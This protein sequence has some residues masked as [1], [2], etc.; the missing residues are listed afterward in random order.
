V[1]TGDLRRIADDFGCWPALVALIAMA[2][3][4][5]EPAGDGQ[6]GSP[7]AV[8]GFTSGAGTNAGGTG[9]GVCSGHTS[10]CYQMCQ[11]GLCECFCPTTGGT[12][13]GTGGA[14]N[15]GGSGG[16][17]GLCGSNCTLESTSSPFC[18]T[19]EVSVVCHGPFPADLGSIM[20]SHACTDAGTGA[21]R[22]CCPA[23][24]VSEC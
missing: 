22:Y 18:A 12:G 16:G 14:A 15:L 5:T 19:A 2:C 7:G 3:S 9:T 10:S 20:S 6:G 1:R 24:I 4:D 8:G 11:G 17:G 21:V 23:A 13:G